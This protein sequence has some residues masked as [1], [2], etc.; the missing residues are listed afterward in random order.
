[1][2][3]YVIELRLGCCCPTLCIPKEIAGPNLGGDEVCNYIITIIQQSCTRPIYRHQHM[4]SECITFGILKHQS[5]QNCTKA[6]TVQKRISI[7]F[8]KPFIN[9]EEAGV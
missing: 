8:I 3:T 7:I 2:K 9:N 1:M 6:Y 5:K 4:T